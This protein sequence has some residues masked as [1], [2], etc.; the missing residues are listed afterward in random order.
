MIEKKNERIPNIYNCKF[1]SFSSC[2]LSPSFVQELGSS[3]AGK[4]CTEEQMKV[5]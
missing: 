1:S 3:F 4:G 2:A 5:V